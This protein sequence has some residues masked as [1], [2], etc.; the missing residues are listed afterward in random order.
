[1]LKTCLVW[2]SLNKKHSHFNLLRVSIFKP[3]LSFLQG[4]NTVHLLPYGMFVTLRL[5]LHVT[6]FSRTFSEPYVKF[7]FS[8]FT[9]LI[10]TKPCIFDISIYVYTYFKPFKPLFKMFH[11]ESCS[12]WAE[13]SWASSVLPCQVMPTL[14]FAIACMQVWSRWQWAGLLLVCKWSISD[15]GSDGPTEPSIATLPGKTPVLLSLSKMELEVWYSTWSPK[16][17]TSTDCLEK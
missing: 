4:L 3:W 7:L 16:P 1:M 9:L 13:H 17:G 6:R 10:H 2:S 8:I 11:V 15:C 5:T 14:A 12:C